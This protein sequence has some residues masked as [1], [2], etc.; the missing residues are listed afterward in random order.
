MGNGISDKLG[1]LQLVRAVV[2]QV[3]CRVTKGPGSSTRRELTAISGRSLAADGDCQSPRLA[4]AR[5]WRH[6]MKFI[7]TKGS[8]FA[9]AAVAALAVGGTS[10]IAAEEETLGNNLSM[11]VVFAEGYGLTG[12]KT[13]TYTTYPTATED[14]GLRPRT[15]A[16]VLPFTEAGEPAPYLDPADAYVARW[17]HVLHAGRAEHVEGLRQGWRHGQEGH[18]QGVLR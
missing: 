7:R 14:D 3:T 6:D 15:D 8:L 13:Q 17:R 2:S 10:A 1:P 4:L 5:A 16:E 18:S 12:M 11:P 9:I